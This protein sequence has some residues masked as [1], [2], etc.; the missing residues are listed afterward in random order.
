MNPGKN[1]AR[2]FDCRKNFNLIDMVMCLRKIALE[3]SVN[4]LFKNSSRGRIA[5]HKRKSRPHRL[6]SIK[7]AC[8]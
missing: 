7:R 1:P 6:Q 4:F 2:C 8:S 3:K 5:Q